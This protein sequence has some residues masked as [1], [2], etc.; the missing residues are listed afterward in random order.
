M[1]N[2]Q[3]LRCPILLFFQYLNKRQNIS[4]SQHFS[5]IYK[6][7]LT[8]PMPIAK[9]AD[10]QSVQFEKNMHRIEERMSD[11]CSAQEFRNVFS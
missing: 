7:L 3:I 2:P 1:S 4:L 11:S 10:G 8:K 6:V 5:N 9:V